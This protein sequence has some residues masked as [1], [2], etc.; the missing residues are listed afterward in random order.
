L[1]YQ[2]MV[3][4]DGFAEKKYLQEKLRIRGTGLDGGV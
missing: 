3:E 2:R 4:I 1:A